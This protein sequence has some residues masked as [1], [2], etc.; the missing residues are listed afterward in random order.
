MW[1]EGERNADNEI[2]VEV[3]C[4]SEVKYTAVRLNIACQINRRQ[5]M[6]QT[7]NIVY[8]SFPTKYIGRGSCVYPVW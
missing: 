8:V 7:S 2:I 6:T 4:D 5:D 1:Q 3:Q